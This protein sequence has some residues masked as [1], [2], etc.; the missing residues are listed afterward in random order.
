MLPSQ[1]VWLESDSKGVVNAFY[2]PSLI[3]LR[4]RNPW[5]NCT[6]NGLM[7]ICSHI[8]REGNSCADTVAAMGHTLDATTWYHSMPTSLSVDFA[9]DIH[10]LPNFRF[11]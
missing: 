7:V 3:P 6:H 8:Y 9:R 10:G 5:H 11:P 2:N 1:R 4:F